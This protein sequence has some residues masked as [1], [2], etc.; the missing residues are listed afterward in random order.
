A[1]REG[2]MSMKLSIQRERDAMEKLW[3]A[4]E[5]QLEK[6]MLNAAHIRGSIEGIAGTDSIQLSL[7]DDDEDDS[8]LLGL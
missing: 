3:K 7:T 6:V 1:I 8:L 5:K 4:R 2:F